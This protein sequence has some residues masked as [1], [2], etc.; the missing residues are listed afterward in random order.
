MHIALQSGC[1]I[2]EYQSKKLCR[3]Q[4]TYTTDYSIYWS[5]F[6]NY[7][8][9]SLII[10][11]LC[12]HSSLCCAQSFLL[13]WPNC[14]LVWE[15]RSYSQLWLTITLHVFNRS[16]SYNTSCSSMLGVYGNQIGGWYHICKAHHRLPN[17]CIWD[18]TR[19]LF[20]QTGSQLLLSVT[21][22]M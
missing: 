3:Q 10:L 20:L 19:P 2:W 5:V 13:Y 17:T 21:Y 22:N 8:R 4:F 14:G 7:A 16:L 18:T 12:S 6:K 1:S 9:H 15:K 11:A